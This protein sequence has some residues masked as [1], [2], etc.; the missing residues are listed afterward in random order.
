MEARGGEVRGG[1]VK[2]V[3]GGG[4]P[5][6]R[7]GV[8]EEVAVVEFGDLEEVKAGAPFAG[9]DAGSDVFGFDGAGGFEIFVFFADC[10]ECGF[11]V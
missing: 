9:G 7:G 1:A 8:V 2:G 5:F 6:M 3:Q 11:G 10:V 4:G